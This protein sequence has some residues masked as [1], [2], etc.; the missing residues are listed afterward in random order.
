MFDEFRILQLDPPDGGCRVMPF[1]LIKPRPNNTATELVELMTVA[2]WK[3]VRR[4]FTRF[5]QKR[6]KSKGPSAKVLYER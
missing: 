2:P 3:A 6:M 4:T 5:E 1:G